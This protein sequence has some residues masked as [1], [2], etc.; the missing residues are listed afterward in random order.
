[1]AQTYAPFTNYPSQWQTANDTLTGIAQNGNPVNYGNWYN[2]AKTTAQFDITDAIRQ[3]VETAGM[4]GQRWSSSL[5]RTGQ[6]IAGRTMAGLGRDWTQMELGAQQQGVQ[7]QMGAANSLMGLGNMYSQLPMDVANNM[8]GMGSQMQN[9]YNQEISPFYN[10]W[11]SMQSYNS[12]WLQNMM[13]M[14]QGSQPQTYD[15]SGFGSMLDSI[16]GLGGAWLMGGGGNPF[17]G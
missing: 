2:Q 10:L 12:P 11:N 1:M 16:F 8:M 15:K 7:N 9:A 14:A 13:Q 4:G 5:G 6:D 3:A 17:K